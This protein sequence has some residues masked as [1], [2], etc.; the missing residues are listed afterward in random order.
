MSPTPHHFRGG[1]H[2]LLVDPFAALVNAVYSVN[3]RVCDAAWAVGDWRATTA[4]ASPHD[5]D[6]CTLA[7]CI[8]GQAHYR[9][10]YGSYRVQAGNLLWFPWS[11]AHAGRSDPR[12]P[13][14]FMS[15]TFS[16][17]ADADTRSRLAAIPE[18]ITLKPRSRCQTLLE[19]A[20]DAWTGAE[21][22]HLLRC[23]AALA[24]VVAE[25]VRVGPPGDPLLDATR[26]LA[27]ELAADPVV[28]L[29]VEALA[30][31]L[32]VGTTRL[33]ELFRAAT[34]HTPTRYQ[35]LQ[36]IRHARS[37]I[38]NGARIQDAAA[39]VGFDDQHYFSRLC[40]RLT[41]ETPSS[42]RAG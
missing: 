2:A 34:G 18:H 23:Q 1:P 17:Q 42:W 24:G 11:Q 36:R 33:R 32:G 15:T 28:T 26:Q 9:S 7:L 20:L 19:E 40:R 21:A 25:L 39:A 6:R 14:T 16:L 8:A 41:G 29:N 13:W 31:R 12:N 37:L 38:A 35:N 5:S 3:R 4:A 30:R 10:A 27:A 22:G